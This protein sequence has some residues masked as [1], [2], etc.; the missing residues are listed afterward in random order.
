[1][2]SFYEN[3]NLFYVHAKLAVWHK[4]NKVDVNCKWLIG[5]IA[6]FGT[7]QSDFSSLST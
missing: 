7:N 5:H 1:M 6:L 3:Y 2:K 4:S